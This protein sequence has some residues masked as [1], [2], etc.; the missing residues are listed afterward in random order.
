MENLLE[1]Q[2]PNGKAVEKMEKGKARTEGSLNNTVIVHTR[3]R[4]EKK[5]TNLKNW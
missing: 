4:M 1:K 5:G 2:M 3:L